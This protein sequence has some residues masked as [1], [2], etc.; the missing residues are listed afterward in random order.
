MSNR[1]ETLLK[2][3]RKR[4]DLPWAGNLAG[5]QR[6]WFAL[7]PPV[8][9]R[10]LR[11]RLPDFEM[12][13]KS[14]MHGWKLLDLTEA[15]PQWLSTHAY[16]DSYFAKASN[17]TNAV[18]KRFEQHV[19]KQL[20]DAATTADVNQDTVFA[21]LGVG[22]LFGVLTIAE[23]I[24]AAAEVVPGRLL[25]FFPGYKTENNTYKLLDAAIAWNYLAEAIPSD[26]GVT[27]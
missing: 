2:N 6:V 15:C 14:A 23:V 20:R 19:I 21:I 13:T 18:R 4:V 8:E 25:V 9:E 26:E 10:R 11:L 22:S 3:Y 16:R 27:Q 24:K 7:Y 12:E 17:F 1:I 5:A